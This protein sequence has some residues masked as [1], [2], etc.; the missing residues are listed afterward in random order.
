MLNLLHKGEEPVSRETQGL[1]T[2]L[3]PLGR[4]VDNSYQPRQ[5]NDPDHVLGIAKSLIDLQPTLPE[6]RGL[7]QVPMG[8]IVRW[9]DSW[10]PPAGDYDNQ[11]AIRQ[12]L[13]DDQ[14]VVE[15][16]F[17]HS[18]RLAFDVLTNGVK[19]IFP[20]LEGTEQVVWNGREFDPATYAEMP[21]V[22]VPL[23]DAQMWQQAV[24]E[25]A[26]RRD[27]SAIEK[28]QALQ[29]AT[30]ELGMTITDAAAALDMSR[31]AASN[32]LRLLELPQNFQDAI[33]NGVMSET[34]GRTLL[35]L[36]GAWHL[37]KGTPEEL[38]GMTRKDLEAHVGRL[39]ASCA[40][41][42]P[43]KRTSYRIVY[44][45][46]NDMGLRHMDPPAWPYDWKPEE[47][48][49]VKGACEGCPLRMT[50]A[51]EPGPRCVQLTPR[52]SATCYNAKSDLW[53]K[54]QMELQRQVIQ[55]PAA[56]PAATVSRETHAGTS[57]TA[58]HT[59]T[60]PAHTSTTA[61]GSVSRETQGLAA[62]VFVPETP[63]ETASIT[64]F[65]ANSYNAPKTLIEKGLCS[66]EKCACFVVAFNQYV[67]DTSVRPDPEH[68]PNMC[69]GCTSA[70]R[71]ARR[72]QEMEHGDMN[73]KRAAIRAQNAACAE[74]LRDAFYV[75]T[76]QDLWHNTAFMRDMISAGSLVHN[77]TKAQIDSMD[78]L[79]IQERIWL[80]VARGHCADYS[81]FTV[82]GEGRHWNMVKVQA[83]LKKIGAEFTRPVGGVWAELLQP[84]TK[85]EAH[86][87]ELQL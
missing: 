24:I 14:F 73:A 28:A 10:Q 68:A 37:L 50:F 63:K 38:G 43:E 77:E 87:E 58:E 30:S 5:Y 23:S 60:A 79:A 25:N 11:D 81:Q 56:A 36:K 19:A 6:T 4:L 69:Y 46:N 49:E 27:I 52:G 82:D 54:Q 78:A 17:G 13:S 34:H 33:V 29:R 2:Y 53:T 32:M 16:A 47:T 8:R 75:L 57:K 80:Q 74:L 83:W 26:A 7:Q 31:S 65:D 42:A 1:A 48:A 67:K 39:I 70:Q 71:L 35:P 86:P 85:A 84:E 18:R 3:V 62:K 12:Y 51:G 64:W 20:Q 22:L 15:M 41:L 59:S 76:A 40:P 66:A 44:G 55:R 45:Y 21:I 61:A 9:A 72:K